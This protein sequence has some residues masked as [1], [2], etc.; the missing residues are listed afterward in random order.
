MSEPSIHE[1]LVRIASSHP[2]L[3]GHFP[4]RPIVP[5][6]V[7]LDC[8]LSETQRWLGRPVTAESLSQAKFTSPL[9][10][11]RSAHL[12]L[13]LSG[14]ELRFSLTCDAVSVAQGTF[15]IAVETGA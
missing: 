13:A 12:R 4:G 11:E 6:V 14:E 8:V 15:K 5:A 2:A 3:A 7:L 10:P 9:L 1:A